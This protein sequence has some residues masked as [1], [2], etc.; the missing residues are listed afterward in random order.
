[1]TPRASSLARRA[2]TVPRATP[3]RRAISSSPTRGCSRSAA[4]SRAS[5]SSIPLVILTSHPATRPPPGARTAHQRWTDLPAPCGGGVLPATTG[6]GPVFEEGR[7][8]SPVTEGDDGTIT[9]RLSRDHP[10]FADEAY[11]ARRAEIAEHALRWRP[12]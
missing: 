12:G 10:G 7:L 2:C 8:C 11:R 4:I 1:M 5:S 6:G 9:V 3:R